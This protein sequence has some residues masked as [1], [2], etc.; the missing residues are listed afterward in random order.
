M[1]SRCSVLDLP[2]RILLTRF[3]YA[4]H[5]GGERNSSMFGETFYHFFSTSI[6]STKGI[7]SFNI[8]IL[9]GG[10]ASQIFSNGGV[11]YPIEDVA[12][13]LPHETLIAS[14]GSISMSAAAR[15]P[16]ASPNAQNVTATISAP[17][18]QL[19]T[20]SPT[21]IRS[22]VAFGKSGT[23]GLYTTYTAT[24]SPVSNLR[25]TTL[26]LTAHGARIYRDEFRRIT[27]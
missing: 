19:G 7:S 15:I 20:F 27:L 5:R 23:R 8:T 9:R 24:L 4:G 25:Q 3:Q 1:N 13:F 21:I 6:D 26:D 2:R 14:D 18:P 17:S 16:F 12:L 22:V 10:S 11:G